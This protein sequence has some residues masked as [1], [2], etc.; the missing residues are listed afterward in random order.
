ML[1]SSATIIYAAM[2]CLATVVQKVIPFESA[3]FPKG[4]V[5][6][7]EKI[8]NLGSRSVTFLIAQTHTE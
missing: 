6:V 8:I 5:L 7:L 4:K 3:G 2:P 1:Y